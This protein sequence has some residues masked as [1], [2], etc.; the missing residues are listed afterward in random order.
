MDDPSDSGEGPLTILVVDDDPA[1]RG[2]LAFSLRVEGFAVRVYADGGALLDDPDLPR[3][4]C[5]VVDYVMPRLNG[6]EVVTALRRRGHRL[7][8]ILVT[9]HPSPALRDSAAAAGVRVV[10]KPLLGDALFQGIRAALTLASRGEG[11]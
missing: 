2:A 10:E 6:L 8:A 5:L 1:V 11:R 3:R 7:P 9:S 4:G